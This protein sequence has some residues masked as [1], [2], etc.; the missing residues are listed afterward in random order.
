ML[1]GKREYGTWKDGS[2]VYKD[3]AGYYVV[4]VNLKS[5]T[6]PEYKKYLKGWK[7]AKDESQLCFI[8][9]RWTMCK[10]KAKGKGTRKTTN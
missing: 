9:K 2:S 1:V 5:V 10:G 4:A 7:P 3:K 8:K 6:E